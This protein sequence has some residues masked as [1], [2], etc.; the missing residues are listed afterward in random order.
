MDMLSEEKEVEILLNLIQL[1]SSLAEDNDKG[2]V[3]AHYALPQLKKFVE[4][5]HSELAGYAE[6]A[7]AIVVWKP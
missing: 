2:R 6:D 7:I 1:V 5:K 3:E 4:E